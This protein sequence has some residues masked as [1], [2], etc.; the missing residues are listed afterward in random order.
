MLTFVVFAPQNKLNITFFA[1]VEN[2]ETRK[3]LFFSFIPETYRSGAAF[4]LA[5]S[6]PAET[7]I[8]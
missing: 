5:E 1:H 7:C 6:P 3:C 8:L 4:P 2:S